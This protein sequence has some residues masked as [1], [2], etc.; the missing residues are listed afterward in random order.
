VDFNEDGASS[1][2][3]DVWNDVRWSLPDTFPFATW[4]IA[5]GSG[6]NFR[7]ED[8]SGVVGFQI[9]VSPINGPN[10]R[11]TSAFANDIFVPWATSA[12]LHL[13]D[14]APLREKLRAATSL[15]I[16]FDPVMQRYSVPSSALADL[17]HFFQHFVSI[18]HLE[19]GRFLPCLYKIATTHYHD[20]F[21]EV[22]Y[23]F[24][25]VK[26]IAVLSPTFPRHTNATDMSLLWDYLLERQDNTDVRNVERILVVHPT[27]DYFL[28]EQDFSREVIVSVNPAASAL[29]SEIVFQHG[30]ISAGSWARSQ[31]E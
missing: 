11:Q 9:K 2:Y 30:G 26:T 5:L 4:T 22:Q 12:L 6:L 7:G 15:K 13:T 3:R 28:L 8:A 31:I 18:T 10:R 21:D 20:D 14:V 24:S 23:L 17:H 16:H 1:R 27:T 25:S 19:L 29:M